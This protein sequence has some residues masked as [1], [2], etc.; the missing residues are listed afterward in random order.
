MKKT[1]ESGTLIKING[2]PVSLCSSVEVET[3]PGNAALIWGESGKIIRSTRSLMRSP[4]GDLGDK[5]TVVI[6]DELLEVIS[7]TL[8]VGVN[9]LK[10]PIGLQDING[11]KLGEFV[12]ERLVVALLS[13]VITE[14]I[15]RHGGIGGGFFNSPTNVKVHPPLGAT[16]SVETGGDS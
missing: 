2:L 12:V 15:A 10:A 5:K 6:V 11:V 8:S 3:S 1:L 13:E 7:K 9:T 14:D 4:L 16:A